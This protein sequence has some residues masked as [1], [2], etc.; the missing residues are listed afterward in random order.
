MTATA[1]P[2]PRIISFG[3]L[4]GRLWGCVLAAGEP[5]L[6]VAVPEGTTSGS[7][8][9]VISLETEGEAW[10]VTGPGVALLVASAADGDGRP[11]AL[12][13]ELCTVSGSIT[14]AG[15]DRQVQALATASAGDALEVGRLDSLRALSGWFEADDGLALLSLRPSGR[16]DQESDV[17]AAT[18]FESEGAITVDDPRLSTT[19][20]QAEQPDR[21]SVEL[22]I[23]EGEEQYPRRA[24]AEA[25][26]EAVTVRSDHVLL[27]VTPMRCHK[28]GRDGTGVYVL[29]RFT[30]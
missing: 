10:R 28:A 3:D 18:L 8:A 14:V 17:V 1:P 7:G 21:A 19:Y 12:A 6:V 26:G 30:R 24:A 20:R 11:A 27:S 29:A 22:W 4:D 25:R 5:L 16:H 13:P 23:G 9:D 2:A 15:S